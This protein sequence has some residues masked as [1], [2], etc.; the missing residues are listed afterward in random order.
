MINFKTF[1]EERGRELWKKEENHRGRKKKCIK[2]TGRKT[3]LIKSLHPSTGVR[4]FG[5]NLSAGKIFLKRLFGVLFESVAALHSSLSIL[6]DN[7][8]NV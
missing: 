7:F 2:L 4:S 5:R 6:G 8:S 1:N 3:A